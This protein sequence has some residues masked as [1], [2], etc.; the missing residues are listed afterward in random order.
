MKPNLI[1]YQPG[2]GGHFLKFLFSLHPITAPHVK[3]TDNIDERLEF[4]NFSDSKKYPSWEDFHINNH[5]GSNSLIYK[6]DKIL[7][8]STHSKEEFAVDYILENSNLY[9]VSLSYQDFSNFWL[10]KT[11]EIW[12]GFPILTSGEIAKETIIKQRY[13]YTEINFDR[14][15]DQNQWY[16]EYVTISNAMG[17]P[18]VNQAKT[19][20]ESWFNVRVKPLLDL[21][22]Q[23]DEKE[24]SS[25]YAKRLEMENPG[26]LTN[27]IT[28]KN[29]QDF[30]SFS[31]YYN[32][33][34][35]SDWPDLSD[36][37]SVDALPDF[38]KHELSK[39][40]FEEVVCSN[41]R[42]IVLQIAFNLAFNTG[43]YAKI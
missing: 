35:G 39:F 18:L 13:K 5:K 41:N 23:L 1:I 11:K 7:I 16:D 6:K 10:T 30:F 19:L 4:Y 12:G 25:Y 26:Y 14:F 28:F 2:F 27:E 22:H 33:L 40:N 15:L 31:S 9:I 42:A 24:I 17:I 20:Y 38:V 36:Y 34:K 21:Y 29:S 37:D 43:L 3:D 32:N 8:D